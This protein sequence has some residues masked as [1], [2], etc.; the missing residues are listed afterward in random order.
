M[1]LKK[2]G[3]VQKFSATTVPKGTLLIFDL[4]GL[5]HMG[6]T[7]AVNPQ[8]SAST[9]VVAFN[10]SDYKGPG[11]YSSELIYNRNVVILQ[12]AIICPVLDL[13]H[14]HSDLDTKFEPGSL[15][16][17]GDSFILC[18]TFNKQP[19]Y[20]DVSDG[21]SV[22]ALGRSY[23]AYSRWRIIIENRDAEE[24]IYSYPGS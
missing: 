16:D 13:G 10:S 19:C 18:A 4:N 22:V 2:F 17:S 24:T 9:E 23:V 20:I 3:S 12:D 5:G 11:I 14:I 6:L 7:C 8:Q 1:Q 21:S 15:I